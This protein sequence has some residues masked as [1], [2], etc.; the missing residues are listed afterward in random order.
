[1]NN[2]IKHTHT[3]T[4]THSFT[5]VQRNCPR[6]EKT[7]ERTTKCNVRLRIESWTRKR[8]FLGR[9]KRFV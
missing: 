2:I 9:W 5:K 4:H 6:L 8:T 7:K 3:H 1:M